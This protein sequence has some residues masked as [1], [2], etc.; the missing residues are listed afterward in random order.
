MNYELLK[1][2]ETDALKLS[3]DMISALSGQKQKDIFETLIDELLP[4]QLTREDLENRNYTFVQVYFNPFGEVHHS[5]E[6][7]LVSS[8]Y[9]AEASRLANIYIREKGWGSVRK[10]DLFSGNYIRKAR[11][12]Y[13]EGKYL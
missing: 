7:F 4:S 6:N 2:R 12:L 5:P 1:G 11:K 9:K 13:D 10:I 3:I 8:K